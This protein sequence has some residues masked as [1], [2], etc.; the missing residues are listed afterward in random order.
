MTILQYEES[1]EKSKLPV[2]ITAQLNGL[3]VLFDVKH[4]ATDNSLT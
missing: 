2:L 3:E 1:D 4:V